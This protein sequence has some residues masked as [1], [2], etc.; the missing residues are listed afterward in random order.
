MRRKSRSRSVNP[1]AFRGRN[2]AMDAQ[3]A[4][5]RRQG[6]SLQGIY[7]IDGWSF[8]SGQIQEMVEVLIVSV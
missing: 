3:E 2:T 8:C 7:N 6:N 1:P 4:L 5:A